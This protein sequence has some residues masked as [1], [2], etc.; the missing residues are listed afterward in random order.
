[1]LPRHSIMLPGYVTACIFRNHSLITIEKN[2]LHR[3]HRLKEYQI[4]Y[5][6]NHTVERIGPEICA[7]ETEIGPRSRVRVVQTDENNVV[8]VV[9]NVDGV[10]EII[11][12]VPKVLPTENI[13]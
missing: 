5:S 13:R 11:K 4:N 9:C 12:I 7:L 10:V 2:W 6:N 8:V 3:R 1:M